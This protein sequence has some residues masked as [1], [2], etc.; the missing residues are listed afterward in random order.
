MKYF[1]ETRKLLFVFG[2]LDIQIQRKC[3]Q[4]KY[5]MGAK[6][7]KCLI[8]LHLETSSQMGFVEFGYS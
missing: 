7:P 3:S 2:L 5:K 6:R 8:S 4:L 1:H